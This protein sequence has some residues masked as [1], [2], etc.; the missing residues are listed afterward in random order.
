MLGLNEFELVVPVAHEHT[1]ATTCARTTITSIEYRPCGSRGID[2]N[3]IIEAFSF[4]S[5]LN[6]GLGDFYRDTW[7]LIR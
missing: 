5:D 3:W 4:S 1:L 7:P 6:D 2:G